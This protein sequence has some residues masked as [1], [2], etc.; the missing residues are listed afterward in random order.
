MLLR[1]LKTEKLQG[2]PEKH[3]HMIQKPMPERQLAAY[4]QSTALNDIRGPQGILG[5]I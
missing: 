3:E 4:K 5:L 1:R 2:L